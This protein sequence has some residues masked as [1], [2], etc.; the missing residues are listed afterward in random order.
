MPD[1]HVEDIGDDSTQVTDVTQA[2]DDFAD[3]AR[4]RPRSHRPIPIRVTACS[5][6]YSLVCPA[7]SG[8]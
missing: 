2:L 4:R 6:S 1:L 3:S 7:W 5:S 8:E